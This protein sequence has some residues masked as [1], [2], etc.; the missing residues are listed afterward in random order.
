VAAGTE[1]RAHWPQ[2]AP[3]GRSPAPPIAAAADGTVL[4]GPVRLS[5]VPSGPAPPAAPQST[6]GAFA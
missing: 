3:A 4:S 5:T 1:L 6:R 2:S